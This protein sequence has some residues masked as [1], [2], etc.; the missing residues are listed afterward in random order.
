MDHIKKDLKKYG[1]F[2]SKLDDLLIIKNAIKKS[3]NIEPESVSVKNGVLFIKTNNNYES[4]ELRMQI[5]RL[6]SITGKDKIK[7]F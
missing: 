2:K 3:T 1:S 5:D 6:K 7:I 4:L